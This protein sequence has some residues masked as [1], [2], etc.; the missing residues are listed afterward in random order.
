MW[1]AHN[2]K[3]MLNRFFC[4]Q[5]NLYLSIFALE[6]QKNLAEKSIAIR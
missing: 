1:Y 2:V 6:F 5:L 4:I 3:V